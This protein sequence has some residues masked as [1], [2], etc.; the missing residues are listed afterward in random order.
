MVRLRGLKKNRSQD[1][2]GFLRNELL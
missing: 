1:G 2:S